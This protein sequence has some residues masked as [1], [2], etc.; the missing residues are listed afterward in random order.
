MLQG[1]AAKIAEQY[2]TESAEWRQAA[3]KLRQPFWDWAASDQAVLPDEII[4]LSKLVIRA[5]P[6]GKPTEVD[7]PFLAYKFKTIIPGCAPPFDKWHT[8]LRH[9]KNDQS[10]V[11]GLAA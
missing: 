7:N 6:D 2:T 5:K 1:H 4:R 10:D 11:D 8:T 3:A 9:P